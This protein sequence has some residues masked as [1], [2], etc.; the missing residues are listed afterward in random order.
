MKTISDFSAHSAKG[1]VGANGSADVLVRIVAGLTPAFC[2]AAM[3]LLMMMLTATTAGA[4]ITGSGTSADPYVINTVND[5]NTAA[6][7]QQYYYNSSDYVYIKL[8]ADLNFSGKTFNMYGKNYN[9]I[10]FDGQNHTISGITINTPNDYPAAPFSWLNAGGTISRLTIANSTIYAKEHVA[11]IVVYNEGTVSD[12][13]VAST[14]TLKVSNTYCGGIVARNYTPNSSTGGTVTGCT[15]GACLQLPSYTMNK[16]ALGGI[17]GDQNSAGTISNCLFNGTVTVYNGDTTLFGCITESNYGTITGNCYCPVG[18]YHAFREGSDTAGAAAVSIVSGI[19]NGAT[20][21][22]AATYTYGG[23]TYCAQNATATITAATNTAFKT[24]SVSGAT[25]SSVAADKKSATV[26]LGTNDVTIT[27]TLQTIGGSCGDNATWTLAQD[28]SGNYTRLTIS[29]SGPMDDFGHDEASIWHTNAAWGY[30]LTSVTIPDG[31]TRIG[32]FAFIGCQSLATVTIGSGVTEIAQGAINHCDEMTQ[33]TLP[34]V[35]SVGEVAFENCAKLERIDFGHNNAVTLATSNAFNAKKLQYIVFPSPAGAVANTATSGNWSGYAS[36]LRVAFGNQLFQ[37]TNE[38]GTPAY[39]IATEQDLR[40]LAAVINANTNASNAITGSGMTFRQT[41]N[42]TLSQTFTPIGAEGAYGK[43]FRGTYDGGD[44]TISG[45]TVNTSSQ[46]AGLF[47]FVDKGTVKNV[48]LIS[49]NVTNNYNN[50]QLYAYAGALA[51]HLE[52][53]SKVENCFVYNPTVSAP[54]ASLKY[55]GAIVGQMEVSDHLTNTHFYSNADYAIAGYCKIESLT[56]SG[57]A[58]MVTLG[59]GVTGITPAINPA[60]TNLD[61]GFV[62]DSKSYYREGVTLTLASNTPAGYAP[63]FIA[64]STTF[65][66]N[67]YTVSD[68]DVTF[69]FVQNTPITY[70]ITYN[71]NGGTMPDGYATTYN[72]ESVNITLPTPT[73]K[74]YTFAGWYANEGLTDPAVTSI[75]HGS[76]GDKQFWAKWTANTYTV[77]FDGNGNTDDGTMSDQSFT[78]DEA[79]NL[80]ANTYTRAFT[81]TYNYNGATGGNSEGSATATATFNGWATSADGQKVYDDNQ[82]VSNLAD[83]NGATVTLYAKW[84]DASVTLPTPTLTGYVFGGWYADSE[85]NT[86]LGHAGASY[87]PSTD[88]TLYAKWTQ[89]DWATESTGTE[90]DPYVI[91]NN[92][93]LDL[94]AQRVNDP[95]GDDDAATGYKGKYFVLGA[96]IAYRHAEQEGGE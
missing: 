90:T 75:T 42:I 89:F 85:W 53:Y 77:Q 65:T 54:N 68:G 10:R 30:D 22:S 49:P 72:I 73:R 93:Q 15:V 3:M 40:N 33:I 16:K 27:A 37:A 21:S 62:Y 26:N 82:S 2:W 76:T 13:H 58:R 45:L 39:K 67:T 46:Y 94:L 64:N 92:E 80:T 81:V 86:R 96:D 61:N 28:D 47:G 56:N 88:I 38:G 4:T 74:G 8:G 60:A 70:N 51:G 12:C 57:R 44:K 9:K 5:W 83:A 52:N 71:T 14:V 11:G 17:V 41:A 79:Q 19:P 48:R 7:T 23:N 31:I 1:L 63:V 20:V 35:T 34:A 69:T 36:K 91:Y 29:G 50:S 32:E 78:Y 55:V 59:S 84:T 24:F 66:G 25:G 95:T 6:T 18:D 43:W 87:T